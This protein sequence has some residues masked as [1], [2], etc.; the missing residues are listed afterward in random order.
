[1]KNGRP[2][3]SPEDQPS[4]HEQEL[5]SRR[6]KLLEQ[7]LFDSKE[8]RCSVQPSEKTCRG[9]TPRRARLCF[10]LHREIPRAEL[11]TVSNAAS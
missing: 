8:I 4:D 11:C 7:R 6:I 2:R 9:V 5:L 1:M 3:Q 10:D